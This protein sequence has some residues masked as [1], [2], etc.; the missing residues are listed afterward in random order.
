MSKE[1]PSI[2]SSQAKQLTTVDYAFYLGTILIWGTTWFAIRFQ[3]GRVPP[4][5]SIA[6]RFFLASF[7]LF[8]YSLIKRRRIPWDL[9]AQSH[10]IGLGFFLFGSNY[11]LQ[12]IAISKI[13]SGLI[14]VGFATIIV[15]NALFQ[16]LF[17]NV[18]LNLRVFIGA[19]I[20]LA[21]IAL[22]FAPDLRNAGLSK[23]TLLGMSL[24]VIAAGISSIGNMF[25]YSAQKKQIPIIEANAFGMAYGATLMLVYGLLTQGKLSFDFSLPY[26]ASLMYLAFFGSILAFGMYLSLLG[27]IG[28]V[29][30]AYCTILFPIIALTLSSLAE[31]Y[32]LSLLSVVG[33][34]LTLAGNAI[35]LRRGK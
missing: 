4:P 3:L 28:T 9:T 31:G 30:A 32:S 29:R 13:A 27:R 12:Y 6:Y 22:V 21:G 2:D 18:R 26:L 14:A 19:A 11:L 16:R 23:N 35:V 8:S 1:T 20:G 5:L 17:F 15:W 34:I 33:V 24:S 25:S 7:L 10:F